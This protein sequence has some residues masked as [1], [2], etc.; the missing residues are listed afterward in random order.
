MARARE[1]RIR[2]SEAWDARELQGIRQGFQ[3]TLVHDSWQDRLKL[4]VAAR[5]LAAGSREE[6][7]RCHGNDVPEGVHDGERGTVPI[8]AVSDPE[9]GTELNDVT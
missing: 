3:A 7:G 9:K 5:H 8:D 2:P 1:T 6:K 4:G